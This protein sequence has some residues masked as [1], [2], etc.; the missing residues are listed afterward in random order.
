MKGVAT[1][2]SYVL[3]LIRFIRPRGKKTVVDSDSDI[4]LEGYPRS[5]NTYLVAMVQAMSTT[6]IRIAR[7]R[8]EVGQILEAIRLK[9]PIVIVYRDPINSAASFVVREKVSPVFALRYYIDYYNEICSLSDFVL[10][11][12]FNSLISDQVGT[13]NIIS[14]SARSLK[15]KDNRYFL[16]SDVRLI[17]NKMELIDSGQSLARVTHLAVPDSGR[18][19]IKRNVISIIEKNCHHL[20]REANSTYSKLISA[21]IR[22]QE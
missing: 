20:L 18:D 15:L 9:K 13:L 19:E 11:I 5:G 17:V 4:V 2:S 22:S 21:T 3:K 1:R 7:H 8:H 10:L 16:D 14:Q 6:P 12:N